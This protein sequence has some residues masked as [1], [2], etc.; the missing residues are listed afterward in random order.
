MNFPTKE[1]VIISFA[2]IVL[3]GTVLGFVT[4]NLRN[5]AEEVSTST[6]PE[7][8]EPE[9]TVEEI[10]REIRQDKKGD[11]VDLS[12]APPKTSLSVGEEGTLG[13]FI[14]AKEPVTAV[15]LHLSFNPSILEVEN[16]VQASFL[17]SPTVLEKKIDNEKGKITFILGGLDGK[18]GEGEV[19]TIFFNSKSP[20]TTVVEFDF[21]TK[22]AVVGSSASGLG[23][24]ESGLVTVLP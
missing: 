16:I 6:P 20:G 8:A 3:G 14:Q 23:K 12:F 7:V 2:A 22:A 21:E 18:K 1:F 4:L 15:E 19:A 5:Q 9:R 24:A 11:F 13:V 17:L 10:E